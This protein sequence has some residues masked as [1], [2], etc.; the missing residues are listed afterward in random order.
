MPSAFEAQPYTGKTAFEQW[1][2]YEGVPMIRDFIVPDLNAV[3]VKSW[4]S[5]W[6]P[7]S[8][9]SVLENRPN[10]NGTCSRS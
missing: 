9:R 3:A 1:V 4:D 5:A 2:E 6:P 7:T 8:A 10:L